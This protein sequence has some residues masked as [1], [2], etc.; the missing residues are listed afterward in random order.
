M[1]VS[2]PGRHGSRSSLRG[3]RVTRVLQ[4]GATA[5]AIL[6]HQSCRNS[7]TGSAV[8]ERVGPVVLNCAEA[9]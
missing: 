1:S 7:W 6:A 3:K 9:R 5:S 2:F 4:S 8:A